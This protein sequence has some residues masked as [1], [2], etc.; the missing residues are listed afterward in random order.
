MLIEIPGDPQSDSRPRAAK[1]G[2]FIKIYDSKAAEKKLTKTLIMCQTDQADSKEI[3]EAKSFGVY[4][5]FYFEP[6]KSWSKKKQHAA[7]HGDIPHTCKPDIDNLVKFYLD[8]MN[9]IIFNDDS[10]VIHLSAQKFY[11]DESKTVIKIYAE[12]AYVC[13]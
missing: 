6:P 8:C 9:K 13:G 4:F 11:A 2:N 1:L 7:I 10:Q 3:S 5:Y 12:N